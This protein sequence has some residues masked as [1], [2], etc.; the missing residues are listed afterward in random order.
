M[1]RGERD[2][3]FGQVAERGVEQAADGIAG[4]GGDGFGGVTEQRGQRDDGQHRQ[5]KQQRMRFRF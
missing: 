2:H 1:Q 3:K 4:P 5:H